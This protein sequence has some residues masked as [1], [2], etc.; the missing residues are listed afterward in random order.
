MTR[1]PFS[2]RFLLLVYSCIW[3]GAVP[4]LALSKRLRH[5]YFQRLFPRKLPEGV[6]LWIQAASGGEAYLAVELLKTLSKGQERLRV[7]VTTCTQ[8]GLEVLEGFTPSENLQYHTALFP[9]DF[10]RVMQRMLRKLDPRLVV[11]LETELWPGLLW[12]C[13]K[14]SVPVLLVNGRMTPKSCRGYM[15]LRPLLHRIAPSRTMAASHEYAQRFARVFGR[16]NVTTMPNMKFD[17]VTPAPVTGSANPLAPI[18]ADRAR[19]L[20][21]FGS[22]RREEEEQVVQVVKELL[23]A[24]PETVVALF[25]RHLHRIPAWTSLLKD[26][27]ISFLL[28]SN[29]RGPA[30]LGCVVLWDTFGEL[31][32]AYE[33][34]R[35]VFVGGTLAPCG[36]QNFLEP[37]TSGVI[38]CIGVHWENFDWVGRE[39]IGQELV[40]EVDNPGDLV[41]CLVQHLDGA[42]ERDAVRKRTLAFLAGK[43]GGTDQAVTA[44]YEFLRPDETRSRQPHA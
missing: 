25:P 21:V 39:I 24:R 36:G 12:A 5:G 33:Y 14:N 1:Q 17:R 30:P 42:R 28:R 22:V 23:A 29:I 20:V 16:D 27:N 15:M 38:P 34:A 8:Q 41:H 7:L 19:Q 40:R 3:Y 44:I 32:A 9:F 35:A 26:Q 11:L 43:Q 10:P 4:F 13:H 37:L 31:G 6:D 18:L 2:I